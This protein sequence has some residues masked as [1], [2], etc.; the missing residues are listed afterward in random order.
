MPSNPLIEAAAVAGIRPIV[1]RQERTGVHMADGFSRISNGKLTGIFLM[2]AGPGAE[3]AF[4]GVAP[5][6]RRFGRLSCCC[7]RGRL[8]GGWALIQFSAPP[9]ATRASPS[10]PPKL[11]T[12]TESRNCFAK[13]LPSCVPA[14]PARW[15]LEIPGALNTEE[16]GE[17]AFDYEPPPFLRTAGR[18]RGRRPGPLSRALLSAQRPIIT[19]G[20]GV[21]YAEGHRRTG[22]TGRVAANPGDD[23]SRGEKR[24]PGKSPPFP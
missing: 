5:S 7:R 4:G 13:P 11:T 23:H 9:A 20:Q 16:I 8:G 24:L 19:A 15:L 10:G 21:L 1:F 12:R 2:Q 6:L 18:P 14:N 3:N 17:E 22:G